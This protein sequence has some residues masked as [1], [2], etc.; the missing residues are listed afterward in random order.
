MGIVT[1][2]PP[3]IDRHR[4]KILFGRTSEPPPQHIDSS[5]GEPTPFARQVSTPSSHSDSISKTLFAGG[6]AP[7]GD[8]ASTTSGVDRGG[9]VAIS[10]PR[11]AVASGEEQW[12]QT[13]VLSPL[14]LA[15]DVRSASMYAPSAARS[16]TCSV[17]S[18][19]PDSVGRS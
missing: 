6:K 17:S 2:R 13:A 1:S 11:E 5:T 4:V 9:S 18:L 16:F 10:A 7:A 3:A 15:A 8:V 14:S 19:K 12:T